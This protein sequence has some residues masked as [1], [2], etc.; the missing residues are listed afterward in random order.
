MIVL[1]NINNFKTKK[2][3]Y[4]NIKQF[5]PQDNSVIEYKE[6]I[7]RRMAADIVLEMSEEDFLKLF[8]VTITDNNFSYYN[9]KEIEVKLIL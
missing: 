6:E 2:M 7:I 1:L 5:N 4:R 9:P 8:T 3:L